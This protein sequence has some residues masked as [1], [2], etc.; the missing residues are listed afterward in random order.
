MAVRRKPLGF[1]QVLPFAEALAAPPFTLRPVYLALLL[2]RAMD[3][4]LTIYHA[5]CL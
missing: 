1:G 5:A 3:A 4:E 2:T